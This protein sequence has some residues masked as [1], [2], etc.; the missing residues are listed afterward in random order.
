MTSTSDKDKTFYNIQRLHWIFAVSSVL[1]LAATVA[2]LV[3]DHFRSWKQYQRRSAK[4]GIQTDRWLQQAAEHQDG[5]LQPERLQ[6]RILEQRSTYFAPDRGFPWLGKRWLELPVLDALNSPRKIETLWAEDLTQDY[7]SHQVLR[8]D[9]C[10]TCHQRIQSGWPGHADRPLYPPVRTLT[11]RMMLPETRAAPE[12]DREMEP[13]ETADPSDADARSVE[14]AFGLVV[15]DTGLRGE[16]HVTVVSVAPGSP[17]SK[18]ARPSGDQPLQSREEIEAM[19][20]G[21]GETADPPDEPAGLWMGDEILEM[22]GVPLRSRQQWTTA[23][24]TAWQGPSSGEEGSQ[25]PEGEPVEETPD[26]APASAITLTVRRGL[27][28]PFAS[29]PRLDL[30]VGASSPH[31]MADFGCTVCHG[32]QGSATS[33]AWASHTPDGEAD[34]DRWR[35]EHRWFGNPYWPDPMLPARFVESACLKCHHHVTDLAATERFP[36]APAAKLLQGYELILQH[37]CYGCHEI[38]GV[39]E[40]RSLGPDLRVEPFDPAEDHQHPGTLRRP[41]PSLRHLAGKLDK[42]LIRRW[43]ANP[44]RLRPETRMP[45]SF[46]QRAHVPPEQHAEITRRESVEILAAA[47]FLLAESRPL[48]FLEPPADITASTAEQQAQRGRELFQTAGCL[49]CHKHRDFPDYEPFR[50]ERSIADGPDLLELSDQLRG[51][52][53][54]RWLY[55]WI[56]QPVKHDPRTRMPAMNPHTVTR[57]DAEGQVAEVSDPTADLVEYLLPQQTGSTPVPPVPDV[58]PK[59][60]D[61]MVLEHLRREFPE[62]RA[63]EYRDRGIPM[64]MRESLRDA[65]RDL[66]VEDQRRQQPG[67]RLDHDTKLR[68]LGRKT[69]AWHGCYGCH[70]IPG[71]EG[72]QPIGIELNDWGRRDP[73]MLAFEYVADYVA[74]QLDEA[75]GSDSDAPFYLRDLGGG[76]PKYGRVGDPTYFAPFYLRHLR[77]GNRIGFL[78][79]KLAEPRSFDFRTL[80]SKPWNDRLR[81]PQPRMSAEEREAVMTFVLGLVAQPPR[82]RYLHQPDPRQLALIEGRKVLDEYNCRGCHAMRAAQ[83]QIEFPPETF[84]AQARQPSFP[85][86]AERLPPQTVQASRQADRRGLLSSRLTGQPLIGDDGR[87]MAFDDYGDEL[88]DDEQY[89]PSTLEYVLQLWEPAVLEGHEY[90]V[91]EAPLYV[92]AERIASKASSDGGFLSNYL[93]PHV[94]RRERQVNPSAKGSEAWGWLPPPLHGLGHR[95]QTPWLRDYLLDPYPMRPAAVMPMPR[96]AMSPLEADRLARYFAAIDGVD[97]RVEIVQR[98]N[99]VYLEEAERAYQQRLLESAPEGARPPGSRLDHALQIVAD[100]NY[101]ITCHIVGDYEPQTSDRA[102]AVDLASLHHRLRPDWL[103]RWIGKPVSLLPYTGMPVNIPYHPDQP[104]EGGVDQAL[105]HGT[106]IE[107][108]DAVVDLLL[109]FDSFATARSGVSAPIQSTPEPPP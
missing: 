13:P 12:D 15:S 49:I 50:R 4:I 78:H 21:A 56:K 87:P 82:P 16:G 80:D 17:A 54:R 41:G 73:G 37:G 25:L 58:D 98:R 27:E 33:F 63:V 36:Q 104:H 90:Q 99:T 108:L 39:L 53:A 76:N 38:T 40:G 83:W 20:M 70:E 93:L 100:R 79:Q 92:L 34:R 69:V 23:V 44:S 105:F 102:K 11:L 30:Y 3:E 101:C 46:G 71:F 72:I 88:F 57:Y 95:V 55:T 6:R 28:H 31:P 19:L 106:S 48:E 22:N 103:R 109:N 45:E 10:T 24:L 68:Y 26:A 77:G 42:D 35:Q 18:A 91:G 67:F 62:A 5:G 107:Q 8:Y 84:Q 9:R 66:L 51:P 14:R 60:L 1:L 74:Q 85:F 47:H 59:T 89:D 32:G 64:Q 65:E 81:M 86:I 29:H 2:M 96:Y 94:V 43:I 97:E 75:S 61:L 52:D 7:H